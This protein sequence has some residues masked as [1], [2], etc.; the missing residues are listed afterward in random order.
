MEEF[1]YYLGSPDYHILVENTYEG[2][3]MIIQCG[4][5]HLSLSIHHTFRL[6]IAPG[7]HFMQIGWLQV[8]FIR[9]K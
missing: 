7:I 8:C 5:N 3:G 4:K 6:I 9:S 2:L 1:Q